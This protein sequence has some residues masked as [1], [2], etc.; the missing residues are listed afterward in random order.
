MSYPGRSPRCF[1]QSKLGAEQSVLNTV[2]KSAEG[3]RG[4]A[5]PTKGPND[6]RQRTAVKSS[7]SA[8]DNRSN[9]AV[10][11]PRDEPA[12]GSP[13]TPESISNSA[14]LEQVLERANLQRALKQVRQNKG[15]PGIDGMS[16]DELP[17]YLRA[18]WLEIR[19]QRVAGSY[20][21]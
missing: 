18:H 11:S 9:P 3:I 5:V 2:E 13:Q 12:A 1:G 10:A 7:G 19:A 6:G 20:C 14:L 16:V 15:A 21:P 8:S 4:R 17:G